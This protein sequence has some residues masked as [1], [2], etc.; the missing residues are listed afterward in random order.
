MDRAA[1]VLCGEK[2]RIV[3]LPVSGSASALQT[4]TRDEDILA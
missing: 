2:R 4:R 3:T 1:D